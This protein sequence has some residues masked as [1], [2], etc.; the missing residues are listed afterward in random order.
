MRTK[1]TALLLLA[2]VT[3]GTTIWCF[4]GAQSHRPAAATG[5]TLP[6]VLAAA[7]A[8]PSPLL[9]LPPVASLRLVAVE[10]EAIPGDPFQPI[11]GPPVIAPT[12]DLCPPTLGRAKRI[13][14]GDVVASGEERLRRVRVPLEERV[15]GAMRLIDYRLELPRRSG[16]PGGRHRANIT[17]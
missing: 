14:K 15:Q 11:V 4:L 17:H 3:I 13:G 9:P 16:I 8:P 2:G 1:L 10:P 7:P 12:A 5:V 6:V